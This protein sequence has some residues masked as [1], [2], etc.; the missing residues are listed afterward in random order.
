MWVAHEL[1]NPILAVRAALELIARSDVP[2][3]E[4]R[5]LVERSIGELTAVS[6]LVDSVLKWANAAELSVLERRDLAE[7]VEDLV[8]EID[9]RPR[10]QVRV[11]PVAVEVDEELIKAALSNLVTNSLTHAPAGTPVHLEVSRLAGRAVVT[12]SDEDRLSVVDDSLFDPGAGGGAGR[13]RRSIGLFVARRI[14]EAHSGR[15]GVARTSSGTEFRVELPVAEGVPRR[16]PAEIRLEE[17]ER[18]PGE[19]RGDR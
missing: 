6:R 17:P 3:E 1:K 10:L 14:V 19:D 13:S 11:Q 9:Q 12:V 8:A 15:L 16:R 2:R 5:G 7:I 4:L 18:A